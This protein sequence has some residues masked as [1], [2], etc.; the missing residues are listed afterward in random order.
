MENRGGARVDRA[1]KMA[2]AGVF[3]CW[4]ISRTETWS[5]MTYE[6]ADCA[7]AQRGVVTAREQSRLQ[8]LVSRT[9]GSLDVPVESLQ[10]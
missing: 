6:D 4:L 8:Q 1:E 9:T 3:C 5:E 7:Y 2:K 10:W